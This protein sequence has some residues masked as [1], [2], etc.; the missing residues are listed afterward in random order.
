MMKAWQSYSNHQAPAYQL[1][2]PCP[3][4]MAEMLNWLLDHSPP[5]SG[6]EK[7]GLALLEPTH[8]SPCYEAGLPHTCRKYALFK[9]I[10]H[11]D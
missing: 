5:H 3:L 6:S 11:C 7:P 4:S 10:W 2:P 8:H 1:C 9:A